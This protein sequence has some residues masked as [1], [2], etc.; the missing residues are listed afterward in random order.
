MKNPE[1]ILSSLA[2]IAVLSLIGVASLALNEQYHWW[3]LKPW[4]VVCDRSGHYAFTGEDGEIWETQGV[5]Q[6]HT[7]A[8]QRM[9]E[10][11]RIDD[12]KDMPLEF[13]R[14]IDRNRAQAKAIKNWQA[15]TEK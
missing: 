5:F 4:S 6:T 12:G 15:C 3:G 7:D 2:L 9:E 1:K 13:Y 14:Q 8:Q 11:H 10:I